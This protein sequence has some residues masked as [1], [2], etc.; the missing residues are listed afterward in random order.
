M[1]RP[2]SGFI[3]TIIALSSVMMFATVSIDRSA[4]EHVAIVGVEYESQLVS[5]REAL[6]GIEITARDSDLLKTRLKALDW[7]HHVN[8]RRNWPSGIDIEVHAEVV[9]AYWNDDGFINEQGRILVT[10]L[11]VGG[12]IPHLYGPA[13]AEFEVMTQY[14]QLGRMLHAYGHDIEVLKVNDRGSWLIET[15]ENIEVLLGKEDLNAR[16]Q[17]FLKISDRLHE[18][19]E[20]R[21]INRMDAR[22]V[23][24]V[25]VRFQKND[26]INLADINIRVGEQSL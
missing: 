7:I 5:I 11:L 20:K 10:D 17:R 8:V 15:E 12:D 25:A 13:G 3:Y 14:Q 16:M 22:Y 19:G 6:S 26:H 24:G 21:V 9:I 2:S 23:N 4:V 18:R 1:P